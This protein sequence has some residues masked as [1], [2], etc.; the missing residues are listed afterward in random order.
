MWKTTSGTLSVTEWMNLLSALKTI[1][2]RYGLGN[3]SDAIQYLLVREG[4]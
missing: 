1:I 4:Q 2:E 3:V